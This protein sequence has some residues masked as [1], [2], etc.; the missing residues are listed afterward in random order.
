M[1]KEDLEKLIDDLGKIMLKIDDIRFRVGE[2]KVLR[3]DVQ[4]LV[5]QGACLVRLDSAKWFEQAP[6]LVEA[7]KDVIIRQDDKKMER[8]RQTVDEIRESLRQL[9]NEAG[10]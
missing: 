3:T 5:R 1:T 2:S 8:I 4:V 6:T 9:E 7:V 10:L